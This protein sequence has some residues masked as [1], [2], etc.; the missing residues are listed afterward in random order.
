M[1]RNNRY[2]VIMAGGSGTRFW[3][4]SRNAKPKQ[5]LDVADTGKTFI[6]QTFERFSRI[7][8]K[9]NI[10]IVTGDRYRDIVMEQIPELDGANLLLEPY[11]RNTAPHACP[12]ARRYPA[13]AA[14]AGD[15][16]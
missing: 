16:P 7:V 11:S 6:R 14:R 3:P 8:P 9:E 13:C 2:C 10:L 12:D 4:M 1:N 5:F 15:G